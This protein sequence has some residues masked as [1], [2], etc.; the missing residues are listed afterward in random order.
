MAGKKK[1]IR[2]ALVRSPIACLPRHRR[3]LRALGLRKIGQV[4]EHDDLPQIRGMIR[5]VNFLVT[6]EESK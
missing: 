3:T 2:V 1:K 5:A 6:V 4:I